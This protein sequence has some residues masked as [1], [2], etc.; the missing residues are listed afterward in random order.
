MISACIVGKN[1]EKYVRNCF[2]SARDMVD[3]IVYL[4][5]GSTD[6]TLEIA[7]EY[8]DKILTVDATE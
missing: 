1:N 6:G 3:E 7:K 5:T 2:G 8:A 4:D